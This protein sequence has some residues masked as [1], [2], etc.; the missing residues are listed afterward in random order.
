MRTKNSKAQ[1][2]KT[3]LFLIFSVKVVNKFFNITTKNT[4][5]HTLDNNGIEMWNLS[6][7]LRN[8]INHLLRSV[9]EGVPEFFKHY[10]YYI[11][12]VVYVQRKR[13]YYTIYVVSLCIQ[14]AAKQ[15]WFRIKY[16]YSNGVS[17]FNFLTAWN[18][19]S[20]KEFLKPLLSR[21]IMYTKNLDK[22][23]LGV[24]GCTMNY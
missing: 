4:Q 1:K 5:F 6:T 18:S 24:K 20:S 8:P 21:V 3:K 15:R 14:T 7:G 9:F 19:I 10:Y 13:V 11:Y 22:N 16:A 17:N 12:N 2:L 23:A